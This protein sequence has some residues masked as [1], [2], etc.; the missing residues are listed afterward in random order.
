VKRRSVSS[1]QIAIV[2]AMHVGIVALDGYFGS[3]VAAVIDILQTAEAVRTDVDPS[4]PE[5]VVEIVAPRKRITSSGGMTVTATRSLRELEDLDVVVLPALGTIAPD[6]TVA[7]VE[8][9]QGRSVVKHLGQ[10]DPDAGCLAAACTG[11]FLL[12]ETGVLDGREATTTWFLTPTFRARYPSVHLDIDRMVVADGPTMTA[13]AAFAHIDLALAMLRGI[14]PQLTEQV[15]RLLL[16]DERLTQTAYVA[17][18]EI[19]HGNPLVLAFEAYIREH[20]DQAFSLE[21]TAQAIGISRRSLERRTRAL[22]GLTP[23]EIVQRLRLERAAHLQRTT[24]LSTEAIARRV[25]Y[26]S[27]EPLRALQ[28]R[29]K[30]SGQQVK[31][32]KGR[33]L[34]HMY[35][36]C[37]G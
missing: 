8:S 13:G 10:L 11:V 32:G 5:L 2:C 26:S 12:A 37:A 6:T 29:T 30:Q 33:D 17:Y 9:S 4:L 34:T 21:A 7:V 19:A 31:K 25:G 23:L 15:A 16:V 18:S 20:L 22:L 36:H 1:D 35:R 14:S 28:R 24:N 27:G 3:A